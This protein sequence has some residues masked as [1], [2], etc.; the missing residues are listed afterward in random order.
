MNDTNSS[1]QGNSDDAIITPAGAGGQL[2]SGLGEPIDTAVVKIPAHPQTQFDDAIFLDLLSHSVSLTK[3]EKI[4][5]INKIPDLAQTQIDR[6][7][8][9]FQEEKVKFSKLEDHHST[10]V[11]ALENQKMQEWKDL[12]AQKREETQRQAETDKIAELQRKLQGFK[13]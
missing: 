12:E 1:P 10:E 9:I 4:K 8:S 7:I 3:T 6:L 5:I 2:P 13:K 11:S